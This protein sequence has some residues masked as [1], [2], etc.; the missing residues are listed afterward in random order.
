MINATSIFGPKPNIFLQKVEKVFLQCRDVIFYRLCLSICVSIIL[1]QCLDISGSAVNFFDM[2]GC[3]FALP[4]CYFLPSLPFHL[5][6]CDFLQCH[7]VSGRAVAF[8]EVL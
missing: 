3:V 1:L 4:I 2:L 7:D 5:C 8:F 6:V